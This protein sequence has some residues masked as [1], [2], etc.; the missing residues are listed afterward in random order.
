[1]LYCLDKS[2]NESSFLVSG[3]FCMSFFVLGY[4]YRVLLTG[5]LWFYNRWVDFRYG[6]LRASQLS[7]A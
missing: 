7:H 2:G 5:L 1:M 4:R 3:S 6:E